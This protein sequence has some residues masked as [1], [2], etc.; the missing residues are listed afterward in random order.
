MTIHAGGRL[1]ALLFIWYLLTPQETAALN[2]EEG[3]H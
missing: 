3:S 2:A 1:K